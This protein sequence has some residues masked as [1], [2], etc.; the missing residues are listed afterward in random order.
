MFLVQVHN[1]TNPECL[2]MTAELNFIKFGFIVGM[3]LYSN[4]MC[5]IDRA[6]TSQNSY[7]SHHTVKPIKILSGVN[8]SHWPFVGRCV[9]RL[10]C[11]CEPVLEWLPLH[12][13]ICKIYFK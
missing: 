6:G 7:N 9:P 4:F 2:L 12:P 5:G 8:R 10:S 1:K 3:F 13:H 11:M